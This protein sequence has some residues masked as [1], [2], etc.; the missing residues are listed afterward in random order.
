MSPYLLGLILGCVLLYLLIF[1]DKINIPCETD[2]HGKCT[3][4]EISLR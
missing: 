1:H 2:K 4:N 3:T